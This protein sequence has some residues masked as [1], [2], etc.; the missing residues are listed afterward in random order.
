MHIEFFRGGQLFRRFLLIENRIELA[1]AN[2]VKHQAM[3]IAQDLFL[4]LVGKAAAGGLFGIGSSPLANTTATNEHL[5]LEKKLAFA[6]LALYVEDRIIVF[7]VRVETENHT[8]PLIG[9]LK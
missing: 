3:L 1:V 5:G 8:T 4:L 2:R 9:L 6:S 7:N